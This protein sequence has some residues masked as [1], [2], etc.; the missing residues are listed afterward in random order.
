MIWLGALLLALL[1][2]SL[3][4]SQRPLRGRAWQLLR[5]AL[6]SWRFFEDIEL[7]PRLWVRVRSDE[8]SWGEWQLAIVPPQRTALA[9]LL[10]ADG[11]QALAQQS[12]VEQLWSELDGM[13]VASAPQLVSYQLV[14][15]IAEA[16]A[17][18]LGAS[19][20]SRFQFLLGEPA[21]AEG[22]YVSQEHG[23]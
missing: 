5:V 19:A 13:E 2:L 10:N 20:M 4:L 16:R 14:Q 7:G 17:R 22:S 15:H 8:A 21:E 3:R 18:A 23:L 9:L 12:V 1:A 11:N 6:P